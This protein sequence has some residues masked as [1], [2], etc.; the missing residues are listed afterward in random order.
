MLYLIWFFPGYFRE[1]WCIYDLMSIYYLSMENWP[2]NLWIEIFDKLKICCWVWP[3]TFVQEISVSYLWLFWL[4]SKLQF[5][6]K[7][8]Y[9]SCKVN[10][11]YIWCFPPRFW[12]TGLVSSGASLTSGGEGASLALVCHPSS[13]GITIKM[14]YVVDFLHRPASHPFFSYWVG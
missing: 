9:V 7:T 6:K 11:S 4:K 10:V 2:C 3:N 1:L 8:T 13:D 5:Y 12:N 14:P